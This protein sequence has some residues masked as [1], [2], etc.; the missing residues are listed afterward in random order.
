MLENL[1]IT[2]AALESLCLT[3]TT[4]QAQQTELPNNHTKDLLSELPLELLFKIIPLLEP[5]A[6]ISL[7]QSNR[8]F[9]AIIAPRKKNF[10]ERLL[11][12]ELV[13]QYG[14]II[15][16]FPLREMPITPSFDDLDAWRDVKY[17]CSV[18]LKLRSQLAFDN[19]SILRLR[20]RKPPPG[21][22]AAEALTSWEPYCDVKTRWKRRKILMSD[23]ASIAAELS[24][25][26]T[27]LSPHQASD[28]DDDINEAQTFLA[29]TQRHKRA[30]ND[31]RAARQ[32]F[33]R[34]TDSNIGDATT[35]VIK[36]RP[37]TFNDAVDR[38]F[39]GLVPAISSCH[40]A[41]IRAR[42]YSINRTSNAWATYTVRC[43][44]CLDWQELANF[45][46]GGIY[47]FVPNWNGH[48]FSTWRCNRCIYGKY[49]PHEL[50]RQLFSFW[51]SIAWDELMDF[52]GAD[53]EGWAYRDMPVLHGAA[54][55][56]WVQ[57][58]E[59]GRGDST[60]PIRRSRYQSFQDIMAQIDAEDDALFF[61]WAN[62]DELP[63]LCAE[64]VD[65][66][67]LLWKAFVQNTLTMKRM[68]TK[69][70]QRR[71]LVIQGMTTEVKRRFLRWC[72]L[73]PTRSR[74]MNLWEEMT[75]RF[76]ADP[77]LLVDW[78]MNELG[79]EG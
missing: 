58:K 68:L 33:Y 30:C 15:P 19:H 67:F 29:G 77:M 64:E 32:D 47:T 35:L 25:L 46:Q 34:N 11:A 21:S 63:G 4:I 41:P 13:P 44:A 75:G 49:G 70:I 45:R 59:G 9:R 48:G 8:Y 1:K 56:E 6:L 2:R 39:P 17:A 42:Y 79:A 38:Y 12:L 60:G 40:G 52:Y 57:E 26:L 20:L 28:F 76:T 71:L 54:L 78:A 14:G 53:I 23:H 43:C 37:Q 62:V 74:R 24:T 10:L 18:C 31:C 27:I 36:S 65:V 73:W 51:I 3:S 61:F 16:V 7:S 66:V 5:I 50:G 72:K 22:A 55:G 69:R